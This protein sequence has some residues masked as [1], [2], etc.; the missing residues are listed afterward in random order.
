MGLQVEPGAEIDGTGVA[1]Y[2]VDEHGLDTFGLKLL[3][4]ENFSATDVIWRERSDT[5]WPDKVMIT[6][7]TAEAL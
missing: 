2:F 5:S 1:T 7:A 6:N 3:A 4:G